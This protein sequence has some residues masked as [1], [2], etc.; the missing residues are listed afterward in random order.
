MSTQSTEIP[1]GSS[2]AH[3]TA[4]SSRRG[5]SISPRDVAARLA[6]MPLDERIEAYRNGT[7]T[8]DELNAAAVCDP[9]GVP[10]R[11]GEYEWIALSLADLD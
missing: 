10:S 3:V 6:R 8:R 9:D 11:N 1:K 7:F 2:Q 4:M 5:V